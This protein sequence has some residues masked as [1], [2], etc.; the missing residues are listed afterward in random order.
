MKN[1]MDSLSE[2]EIIEF[3]QLAYLLKRWI[4]YCASVREQAAEAKKKK[5]PIPEI[6]YS[7]DLRN[8]QYFRMDQLSGKAF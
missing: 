8:E 4:G 5:L 2:Q 7:K 1:P 3:S 6:D